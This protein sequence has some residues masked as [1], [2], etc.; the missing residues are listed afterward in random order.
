MDI[1]VFSILYDLAHFWLIW[2][3]QKAMPLK[4]N[5]P[6]LLE[7]LGSVSQFDVTF[8]A[9]TCTAGDFL[10]KDIYW[11]LLFFVFIMVVLQSLLVTC[12][13]LIGFYRLF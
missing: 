8:L 4:R 7:Y 13:F 1:L 9:G 3:P 6:Q 2:N 5:I 12:P 11:R 10:V